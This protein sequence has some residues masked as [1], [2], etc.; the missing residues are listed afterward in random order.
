VS[1]PSGAASS[2]AACLARAIFWSLD[3]RD[4]L[5]SAANPAL[6]RS[7]SA[8]AAAQGHRPDR[9]AALQRALQPGLDL[10]QQVVSARALLLGAE[11]RAEDQR[12]RV[13][14]QDGVTV[15]GRGQAPRKPGPAL[16]GDSRP[17]SGR[18]A[19]L[20]G[21]HRLL[22]VDAIGSEPNQ[23]TNKQQQTNNNK[24]RQGRTC[25]RHLLLPACIPPGTPR[26]RLPAPPP[27]PA[28][29]PASFVP[30]ERPPARLSNLGR[31]R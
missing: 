23:K 28:R 5:L 30:R 21:E 3:W 22:L 31:R 2:L 10:L 9:P 26:L 20:D 1:G 25:P 18:R 17:E 24:L 4:P 27:P 13:D 15:S 29:S 8:N 16:D 11:V 19:A 14:Q 6:R 7:V 12:G